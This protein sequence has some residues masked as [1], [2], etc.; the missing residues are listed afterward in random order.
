MT[1]IVLTVAVNAVLIVLD[2]HP[3]RVAIAVGFVGVVLGW[4]ALLAVFAVVYG[5]RRH[6]SDADGQDQ[7]MQ[8]ARP[9][10]GTRPATTRPTIAGEN[11]R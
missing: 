3:H 4:M 2:G 11:V 9:T 10:A 8:L 7:T 1:V 5:L 6:Q